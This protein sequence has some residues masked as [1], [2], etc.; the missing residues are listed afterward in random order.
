[1]S[2]ES[3]PRAIIAALLANARLV[4]AVVED[5]QRGAATA[6]LVVQGVGEQVLRLRAGDDRQQVLGVALS[7]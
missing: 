1:M 6:L 7:R 5:H 4:G 3:S 2:T